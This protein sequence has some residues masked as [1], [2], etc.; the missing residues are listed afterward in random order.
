MVAAEA[1]YEDNI[2]GMALEKHIWKHLLVNLTHP[3]VQI[4][5]V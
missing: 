1:T 4:S 3:H 5:A 2:H